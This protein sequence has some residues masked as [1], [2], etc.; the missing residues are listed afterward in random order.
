MEQSFQKSS[1]RSR[2]CV[3]ALSTH[4]AEPVIDIEFVGIR[5]EVTELGNLGT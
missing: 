3:Q 2:I 4:C 1:N 5:I